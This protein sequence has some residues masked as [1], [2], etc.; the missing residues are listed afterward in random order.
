MF[1]K[2]LKKFV[3][4]LFIWMVFFSIVDKVKADLYYDTYQGTG[5]YPSFPGN[6]GS[7]TY[8]TIVKFRYSIKYQITV[9]EVVYVLDSGRNET[10]YCTLCMVILL[11]QVQVHKM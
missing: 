5:A 11:Y 3:I 6:G 7:L 10:S 2:I 4:Y 9:G 8:P 1:Y